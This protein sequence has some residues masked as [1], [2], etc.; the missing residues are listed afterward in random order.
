V[1]ALGKDYGTGIFESVNLKP[2]LK[3]KEEKRL[4][5]W[6]RLPLL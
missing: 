2:K 4:V 5:C 3:L 6:K 1:A